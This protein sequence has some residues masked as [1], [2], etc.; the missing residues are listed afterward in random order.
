MRCKAR[1]PFIFRCF[2]NALEDSPYCLEHQ[3][4][5]PSGWRHSVLTLSRIATGVAVAAV[6]VI[7]FACVR[8]C[9]NKDL[10]ESEAQLN[11][12][13]PFD[14]AVLCL[15]IYEAKEKLHIS[16]E[17]GR[18]TIFMTPAGSSDVYFSQ[19]T[20]PPDWMQLSAPSRRYQ[21]PE[22]LKNG[23]FEDA[24]TGFRAML[25]QSKDTQ[26]IVVVYRGVRRSNIIQDSQ[27]CLSQGLGF[28]AAAYRQA[29][30][31]A[32]AVVE[33]YG[34]KVF[35]TGHS[36][37]GGLAAAASIVAN[38]PAVTFNSAGV[39]PATLEGFGL[40]DAT[41]DERLKAIENYYVPGEWLS[42]LQRPCFVKSAA[43]IHIPLP[44][45]R[46]KVS[47]N[48]VPARNKG[49]GKHSITLIIATLYDLTQ[50]PLAR[51]P[52]ISAFLCVFALNCCFY[53]CGFAWI[54]GG[55]AL[56]TFHTSLTCLRNGI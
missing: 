19:I 4:Y 55:L 7:S 10:K 39:H 1:T 54:R 53:S 5:P 29:I 38:R 15:A 14:Y 50:S 46:G 16:S 41:I 18:A 30:E 35:F 32:I 13:A 20:E 48:A 45:V 2:R 37:G 52:F 42:T 43:G 26:E 17:T 40:D 9:P 34:D 49:R 12:G 33:A 31:L 47:V 44:D 3:N 51:F 22:G 36:M 25:Y 28:G 6:S 23:T 11:G 56:F 21:L 8:N 27:T 24:N